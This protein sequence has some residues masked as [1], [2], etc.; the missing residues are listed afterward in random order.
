MAY[1]IRPATGS[2]SLEVAEV[3]KAVFDEYGFT[4][5]EDDYCAD[6]YDLDE[7]Y[8]RQGHQFWV[9]EVE[10]RIVGAVGLCRH[11]KFSGRAG[12][13]VLTETETRAAGTDC[14]L[15]RLYVHPSARKLGVGSALTE[16]VLAS[17]PDV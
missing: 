14:S 1:Q 6:L 9:A 15:E 5:D 2:D 10:G 8:L 12:D 13:M 16:Q 3:V 11:P 4:W 17:H 7:H